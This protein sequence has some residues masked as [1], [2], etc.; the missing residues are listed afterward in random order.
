MDHKEDQRS[1][2]SAGKEEPESWVGPDLPG[3]GAVLFGSVLFVLGGTLMLTVI[4]IPLGIPLFAAGLGL[5]LT[6]KDRAS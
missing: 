1:Q 3:I 6:P 4:G 5:L 2:I